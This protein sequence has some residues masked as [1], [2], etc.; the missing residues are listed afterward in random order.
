MILADAHHEFARRHAWIER[1]VRREIHERGP[2]LHLDRSENIGPDGQPFNHQQHI[3]TMLP[4]HP[5]QRVVERV[6]TPPPPKQ[7]TEFAPTREVRGL[8][9]EHIMRPESI[10]EER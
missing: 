6:R 3:R 4:S 9:E 10:D 5:K 8:V 7:L 2:D 1:I